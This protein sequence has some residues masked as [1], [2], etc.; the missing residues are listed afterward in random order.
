MKG[1]GV[2][3]RE[4]ERGE[5]R[6]GRN[7]PLATG[8]ASALCWREK[9]RAQSASSAGRASPTLRPKARWSSSTPERRSK[10]G[11]S[12]CSSGVASTTTGRTAR[13]LATASARLSGSSGTL[14]R[15]VNPRASVCGAHAARKRARKTRQGEGGAGGQSMPARIVRQGLGSPLRVL[16]PCARGLWVKGARW[17]GRA[18]P[19]GRCWEGRG[20]GPLLLRSG[21][22]CFR[23]AA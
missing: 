12:V 17:A 13:P 10:A 4:R 8:G 3:Q 9:K 18:A 20:G 7:E 11:E 5:A 15:R 6:G 2:A 21:G 14:A 16:S 19:A 23:A 1:K 22:R